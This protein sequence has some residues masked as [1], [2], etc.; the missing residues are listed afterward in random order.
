MN[1]IVL[2]V[3]LTFTDDSGIFSMRTQTIPN[4]IVLAVDDPILV[5]NASDFIEDN[6]TSSRSKESPSLEI[7]SC[8]ESVCIIIMSFECNYYIS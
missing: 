4:S 5:A 8:I 6:F 1:N 2:C 7:Q 3:L